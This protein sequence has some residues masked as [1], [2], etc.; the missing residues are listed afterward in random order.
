MA[1]KVVERKVGGRKVIDLIH[2]GSGAKASILP[3]YGFNLFDLR[4]P[5]AGA[6]RRVI[7]AGAAWEENPGHAGRN[8]IPILFPFPNRIRGGKFTYLGKTYELPKNN[9][10]NAIHGFAIDAAWDVSASGVADTGAFCT[11]EYRIS[12]NSPEAAS[13]WPADAVLKVTYTLGERSLSLDAEVT[14]PSAGKLPFG[15]G[16]HPYFALPFDAGGDAAKTLIQAPASRYWELRDFL[17]SGKTA[18]VDK[19]LDFRTGQPRSGLKLDD[20]LTGLT[21]EGSMCTC[22]LIDHNLGAT[23]RFS[24]DR[25]FREIVLYTPPD[26]P[27]LIAI[28]PYT[29]TTDAI[30]LA[31]GGV[32]GGLR[33]LDHDGRAAFHI[34]I[35]A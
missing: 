30:N 13:L 31:A 21:Y 18:A 7:E 5:I 34:E 9:G 10:P 29:Q 25:G 28:E 27:R 14:N 24:F 26:N 16:I 22:R 33:E 1:G 2:E 12:K 15:F 35:V 4:L 6:P 3:G 23:L 20:V 32:D 19:R 17:P 11:G 8:G